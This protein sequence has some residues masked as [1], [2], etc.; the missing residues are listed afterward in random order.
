MSFRYKSVKRPDGTLSKCPMIPITLVAKEKFA[1]MALIDSGAD[2][3]VWSATRN[4]PV[5]PGTGEHRLVLVLWVRPVRPVAGSQYLVHLPPAAG[6]RV[7]R[8]RADHRRTSL[9]RGRTGGERVDPL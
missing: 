3:S 4:D 9:H 2:V 7:V 1:V 5:V 8:A 6:G